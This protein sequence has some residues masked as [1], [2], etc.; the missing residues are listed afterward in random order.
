[1]SLYLSRFIKPE[2]RT[3]T[4]TDSS[5]S[6]DSDGSLRSH[7]EE[8]KCR[9]SDEGTSSSY[10]SDKRSYDT[11]QENN[12]F[13]FHYFEMRDKNSLNTSCGVCVASIM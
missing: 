10:R 1:M 4:Y 11:H 9:D 2:K 5:R 6:V 12:N 3:N 13:F 8:D 7:P